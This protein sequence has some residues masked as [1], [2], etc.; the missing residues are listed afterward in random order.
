MSK[1]LYTI[2]IQIFIHFSTQCESGQNNCLNCHPFKNLCT[3]CVKDV[4]KPDNN[5]GCIGAENCKRG[6]N[7]CEECNS[8]DNRCEQCE[9]G[10]FPD[11]NG[12]CS[13]TAN[14]KISYRGECLE[15]EDDYLLTGSE[16]N[17]KICKNRYS[18]D[19]KNCKT[20]NME[21]GKCEVCEDGYYLSRLN[22]VCIETENCMY[23]IYGVC[24]YCDYG[25][26]LDKRDDLCK[27][28]EN[29]LKYCEISLD[30]IN[31]DECKD[32]FFLAQDGNCIYTQFCKTIG[33]SNYYC[34]ECIE[35]Y[36]LSSNDK[37]CTKTQN[38]LTV[39]YL[40][41]L[42]TSCNDNYYLDIESGLCKSNIEENDYKFC[43]IVNENKECTSCDN[44]YYLS[45]DMRCTST[46]NCTNAKNG[47]CTKCNDTFY[48]G[49]DNHCSSV[50]LC[51]YSD[52]DGNC[53]E[54][55]DNY[56]FSQLYGTCNK[57]EGKFLN[58]KISDTK[59]T[60]CTECK[61]DFYLS[62]SDNICY[63]NKENG[64]LYKCAKSDNKNETC[65]ECIN[66]YYLGA[67]DNK[68]SK[69]AY[70]L[71][72]ENENKCIKCNTY[73]C[74]DQ[75]KGTCIYSLN[76]PYNEH[77]KIYYNCNKTNEEGTACEECLND[78]YILINGFCYNIGRCEEEKNGLCV[79][80]K[81]ISENNRS[82]CL[83][84]VFGCEEVYLENCLKCNNELE[85]YTCNEC[86]DGYVLNEEY[87]DCE[88]V[89]EE[90]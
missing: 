48:L 46:L 42:C 23:S 52:Y 88:K 59:G 58:C 12:G 84:P 18:D 73:Q 65:I 6:E 77:D 31:C 81:S 75:S 5:G 62:T 29:N 45:E 71:L 74:L 35:G 37:T 63:S 80:C 68:C 17:L 25:Y 56:Y 11:S 79:K 4:Y 67:E 3:K 30:G 87:N 9:D 54:C 61:N 60:Y 14:C 83:N 28:Q 33:Q 49:L 89:E 47:I 85:L 82:L 64:P 34:K 50:N 70:C 53:I 7:Y 55:E 19:F 66:N 10:Y 16:Y 26:Y 43:K 27:I 51:I 39:D 72:S 36:Y 24:S 22:E 41:N 69:I 1:I 76:E 8:E 90:I 78:D 21:K 2:L 40:S 32:H 20:I 38:C 13:Y 86:A 44:N 15:C 57:T